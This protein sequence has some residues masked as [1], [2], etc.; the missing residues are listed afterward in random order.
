VGDVESYPLWTLVQTAHLVGRGF[1]RV[2]AEVGLTPTQ[3]G[4]LACLIK[5]DGLTQAELARAVLVRPQSLGELITPLVERGLVCRSGP[6][7]RGRRSGL[8]VTAS[9]RA[10]HEAALPGVVDYHVRS[11]GLTPAQLT[12][13]EDLLQTLQRNL[14]NR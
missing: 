7:G 13:L 3:F 9:G 14:A 12:T 11:S 4:V 6:G 8:A 5:D 2:F 10:L 1:A